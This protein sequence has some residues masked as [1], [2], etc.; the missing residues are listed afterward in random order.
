MYICIP[1]SFNTNISH[2]LFDYTITFVNSQPQDTNSKGDYVLKKLVLNVCYKDFW[3]TKI[4]I[5]HFVLLVNLRCICHI[6]TLFDFITIHRS[7]VSFITFPYFMV[8]VKLF[9]LLKTRI[10]Y[11]LSIKI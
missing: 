3:Y 8:R 6:K 9:I 10:L 2:K 1:E 5:K 4:Y 7:L 11:S